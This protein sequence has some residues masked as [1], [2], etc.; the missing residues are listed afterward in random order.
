MACF[1]GNENEIE[2]YSDINYIYRKREEKIIIKT[3][4]K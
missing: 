3:L 4:I 2:Y 1:I